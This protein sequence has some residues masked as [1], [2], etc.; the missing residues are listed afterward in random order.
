MLVEIILGFFVLLGFLYYKLIRNRNY[1]YDR[2]VPNT[3]FKFFYGDDKGIFTREESFFDSILR[4]YQEF[5]GVPF[6]G[7]WTLFGK[8]FLMIR[9]DFDLVRS[10]WVKDFD[11]FALA[12]SGSSVGKS[13]W[14]A[15]RHE[16][17]VLNNVTSASGDEWKDIRSTFSPIFTSGKLRKM[18]P[19]LHAISKNMIGYVAKLAESQTEF[20]TKELAGKFS[21]DG[22]ASCAFGVDSGSFDDEKSEFLYHGKEVFNFENPWIIIKFIFSTIT[23]NVIKKTAAKMGL[24]NMFSY[25]FANEHS[26]FL[27]HIVEESFKQ[28]KESKIKRND[29]IDMMI[30]AVEE[31]QIDVEEKDMHA[32]DQFEED[33][34]IVNHENKNKISYDDVIATAL[35]MLSAGY[36][37][38]GQ[39][40]AYILYELAINEHCQ[41]ALYDEIRDAGGDVSEFSYE[42]IQAMPYLDAVIHETLRKHPIAAFLERVC[43]KEY[44]MPG[45][46]FVI[47]KGGIVRL[48]NIGICYD[49]EI[50]PDPKKFDPERFLRENRG[51][52]S[53]YSFLGFSTG[54]RNC[55]AMRFA[56]FEM[57]ICIASLVSSF[58]FLPCDKTTN[59]IKW[60]PKSILGGA[61]GG[62]WIKCENRLV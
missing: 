46:D 35:I 11:H 50:F 17:I 14:P 18:A 43:T 5:E 36:E 33:A 6:F 8:P 3:G 42:T 57:K 41:D 52:R 49:P 13:I 56:M 31:K 32:N 60:D 59:D 2:N 39:T 4:T 9:N 37:T 51:D 21:I 23:P 26:L 19:L 20:E 48:S 40:M 58:R 61:L 22:I 30:D 25:P 34:K 24:V 47:P 45:H 53:P 38:T 28:R 54:P 15:T 44:K 29:L 10:I 55:L 12:D 27:M 62:L 16:K 7:G 1:W